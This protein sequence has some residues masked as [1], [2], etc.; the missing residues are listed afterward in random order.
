VDPSCAPPHRISLV[1]LFCDRHARPSGEDKSVP[2]GAGRDH[3][4]RPRGDR[5]QARVRDPA[6]RPP[7]APVSARQ[8]R[9]SVADHD[10][11]PPGPNNPAQRVPHRRRTDRPPKWPGRRRDQSIGPHCDEPRAV[12]ADVRQR[13]PLPRC[14]CTASYGGAPTRARA[15]ASK[16]R[17]QRRH[18]TGHRRGSHCP[19]GV[20]PRES[21]DRGMQKAEGSSPFSPL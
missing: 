21:H 8:D 11:P 4:P 20:L 2:P 14:A 16:S 10:P 5:P 17:Y 1:P 12:R 19:G 6:D 18:R 15:G 3:Q 13:Q 7:H 9:A